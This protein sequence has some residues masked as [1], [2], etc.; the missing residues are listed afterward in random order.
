MENLTGTLDGIL[1]SNNDSFRANS[2]VLE[3][4]LLLLL[5]YPLLVAYLRY[6]RLRS[7]Q[8]HYGYTTR[9]SLGRMTDDD[10]YEIQ[11]SIAQLEFPFTF[12]KALQF[13]LF[14][15]YGIP[16]MSK[17]LVATT[18][19]AE[20]STASK[21]YVDTEVLI[22]E[23]TNHKPSDPRTLEAIAR[24]NYIHSL[25][26]KNGSIRDDDM[27]YTLSLFALEP[28]RWIQRHEWR[29][30][31]AF[32]QCAFGTFW[33]SIGDAMG[34]SYQKLQSA[35]EGWEDALQW[36]DDL[37]EWSKQ[38]EKENMVPHVNNRKTAEQTVAIL[39]WGVPKALK[40]LGNNI[41]SVLMDD[42]L[43][44]AM[45]YPTPPNP[46]FQLISL[47]FVV[48]KY[49]LRYF[50]LPRPYMFRLNALEDVG[51]E[52]R[53]SLSIWQAAPYYIKPSLWR[54]WGPGAW[55]SRL[56]GLP[57]PGDEGSKYYPDGYI[58]PEVGPKIFLGKGQE[59]AKET[60]RGLAKT[61]TGG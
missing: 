12:Q 41:V 11:L 39:L 34:I 2:R 10:A 4:C 59:S 51:P 20:M 52:G 46:Y 28:I 43:R 9:P 54:R 48:R 44:T 16:S 60:V 37:A 32:E 53:R 27:L 45:M 26:R 13:A 49:L 30:L 8:K 18:Q 3:T 50:F 42:R 31:E 14:R 61:R 21:R 17:L 58:F 40:P 55:A 19:F 56:M 36:L 35:E 47:V 6:D 1:E 5:L 29:S 22:R 57:V 15:T 7:T 24:M 25:Y 33:K 23:F 38:Y